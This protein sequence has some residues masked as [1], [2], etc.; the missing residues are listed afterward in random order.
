MVENWN[1]WAG[2]T[3]VIMY[4]K[5]YNMNWS[6][7]NLPNWKVMRVQ[8]QFIIKWKHTSQLE[9]QQD[10]RAQQAAWAGSPG[11]RVTHHSFTSILPP[12]HT[13]GCIRGERGSPIWSNERGRKCPN[14]VYRWI[15]SACASQ[16]WYGSCIT[17]P[18]QSGPE[19]Q[20]QRESLFHGIM[21]HTWSYS[22][23]VEGRIA[24]DGLQMD[25]C[26][27]KV[28]CLVCWRPR[29]KKIESLEFNHQSKEF[30]DRGM[31]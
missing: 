23:C 29:R 18:L 19:R 4:P 7:L 25:S 8:Q 9:R 27:W 14:L 3:K 22:L 28:A 6:L 21:W 20:L 12:A 30:G 26:E 13:S 15:S 10:E 16:K 31:G 11:H 5:L 1:V 17:F 2:D 24:W